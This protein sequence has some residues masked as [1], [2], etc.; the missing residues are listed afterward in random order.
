MA[1]NCKENIFNHHHHL[2]YATA[3]RETGTRRV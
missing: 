2:C 1:D 3:R